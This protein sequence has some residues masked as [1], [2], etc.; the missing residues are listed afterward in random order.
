MA[1]PERARLLVVGYGSVLRGDDAVGPRV[2]E[3]V[4]ALQLPGI[5][6][7]SPALLTPEI[8]ADVAEAEAVVFVDATVSVDLE[9]KVA[10]VTPTAS[11]QLLG[12]AAE[13]GRLLAL[14]K[15]VFGH[16]PKAWLLT[17]PVENF[18][19]GAELSALAQ[20][21][22]EEAVRKVSELSQTL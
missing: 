15:A 17:I 7:L 18:E 4:E 13:P 5:R 9:V 22:R 16:A 20:K 3:A 10:A 1:A 11:L 12:H 8:A 19:L 6:T 14:A 21:G 2:A